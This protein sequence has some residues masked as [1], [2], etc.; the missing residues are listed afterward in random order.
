MEKI[1][2]KIIGMHCASCSLR[3]EK[4]LK[5]V[6]GVDKAIVSYATETATVEY[7]PDKA[8]PPQM[9]AAIEKEGYAVATG[10]TDMTGDDHVAREVSTARRLVLGAFALALPVLAISM[11]GVAVPGAAAGIA[12]AY[13]VEAILSGVVIFW[14]GRQFHIGM[15]RRV[16]RFTSDMD[17]LVSL[18]TLVAFGASVY[19]VLT[20]GRAVY[21][22]VGATVTALILLGRYLETKSRGQT[23]SAIA[24]LLALGAKEARRL[25]NGAEEMVGIDEI[26][27][28]DILFVKPGEKIPLD[29]TVVDGISSVDESMLTGESLPVDKTTGDQVYGATLNA[30]GAIKLRVSN[31]ANDTVLAN[32][33]KVVSETLERKAPIE[34][35]VDKVSSV[36][37]PAVI[38]IALAVF[39]VW[40]FATGSAGAALVP[41]IAVL[42][43]A[44]PCA[45]G[46]ATPTAVLVGTGEGAKHGVLIKSGTALEKAK[47]IDTVVF[48]KTGTL[49]LGKPVVTDILICGALDQD[50]LLALAAAVESGS[51][52]P[53]SRAVVDQAREKKIIVPSVSQF[54]ALVGSG[55]R[56]VVTGRLVEIGNEKMISASSGCDT[57]IAVLE[58]SGKTTVR[59]AV[60]GRVI[61][62][63]AIA[64]APKPDA[65]NAV[66]DLLRQGIRVVMIT[67]DN[68]RVARAIGNG[69]GI[70]EVVAGVLPQEKATAIKQLQDGGRSVVFVGDGIND[71]PALV[72][73]DLGIA[74]GTGSDIAIEAGDMVLVAGGPSKVVYALA[75]ARKT[76]AT[77]RQN[78]FWAF[79]YNVIA[80]PVAALGLLNPMIAGGA[81]AFSSVSVVLNALRIKRLTIKR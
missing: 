64:D 69:L 61:G 30:N 24:K 17:T 15:L 41:A 2:L 58:A 73:A 34:H 65:K 52:H 74:M 51:E 48:D 80:V 20:H 76:F 18:G 75:L 49:T 71:A 10:E 68:E 8:K 60:D 7:D 56:G 38:V 31:L 57:K 16:A 66:S 59:V 63:I 14:F 3:L 37:V 72:Q 42:V 33:V 1:S 25:T 43:V 62:V 6:P 32:I 27:V 12:A 47:R 79:F 70:T 50:E 11:F 40:F 39:A 44:C 26:K 35:L 67:G 5:T 29:G 9:Q 36:F 28:G 45:L 53:L 23:S 22:E 81:M 78:L 77:I 21:F 54:S 19:S 46:L 4:A 13:W 55:V